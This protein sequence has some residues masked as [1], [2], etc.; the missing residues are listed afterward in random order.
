MYKNSTI[1]RYFFL[2]QILQGHRHK[3]DFIRRPKK[4][5]PD[6]IKRPENF[7][8][9]PA[10]LP[11]GMKNVANDCKHRK[12]SEIQFLKSS[13]RAYR[14]ANQVKLILIKLEI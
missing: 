14:A 13:D 2:Q 8:K 12:Q 3:S 10:P 6:F 5:R 4:D 1:L 9:R 11:P 7:I